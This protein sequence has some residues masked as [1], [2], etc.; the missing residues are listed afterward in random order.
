MFEI[1]HYL[2]I[3]PIVSRDVSVFVTLRAP[4]S[5]NPLSHRR[6]FFGEMTNN[7]S[8][9][10]IRWPQGQYKFATW[11]FPI[12]FLVKNRPRIVLKGIEL[13]CELECHFVHF[14]SDVRIINPVRAC[15]AIAQIAQRLGESFRGSVMEADSEYLRLHEKPIP[16]PWSIP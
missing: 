7:A 6:F 11:K 13:V 3:M 8:D 14:L 4:D 9:P 12:Q 16:Y 5:I 10:L 2:A 15:I 1:L